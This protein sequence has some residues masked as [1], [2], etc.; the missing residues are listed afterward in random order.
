MTSAQERETTINFNDAEIEVSIYTASQPIA[1]RCAK[2]GFR[3]EKTEKL[4]G[5]PCGWWF[6]CAKA[7]ILLR[8]K[9]ARKALTDEQKAVIAAR[10]AKARQKPMEQG[11]IEPGTQTMQD[12]AT[13]GNKLKD[14]QTAP[15]SHVEITR[16]L[17]T[18]GSKEAVLDG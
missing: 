6:V 16:L 13:S 2:L 12:A 8:K 18:N 3:L 7:C 5:K 4:A 1:N 10:F 15:P 11:E 17:A 14:R 9:P